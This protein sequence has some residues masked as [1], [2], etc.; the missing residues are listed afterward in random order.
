MRNERGFTLVEMIIVLIIMAVLSAAAYP[1][2]Q[3]AVRRE[4]EFDLRENLRTIRQAIDAYKRYHDQ[5][6]GQAIPVQWRT[7][8]GYP[9][10]LE[11]LVEGF[12]PTNV[13][14]GEGNRVRFLRRVP[15]D[16]LTDSTEWGQR[17]SN[18]PPDATTWNGEDVFDVYTKSEALALDG[19]R[20]RDW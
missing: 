4:R 19:T 9:K 6:G 16:P 1:L 13:V 5:S 20:Y 18:D 8:T 7:T 10:N 11:I 15:I 3:N 12:V 17:G 14:G 2:M